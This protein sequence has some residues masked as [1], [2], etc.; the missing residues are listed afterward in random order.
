M[1]PPVCPPVSQSSPSAAA[2]PRSQLMCA[3]P[4]CRFRVH[5]KKELGGYCCI[6]CMEGGDHGPRCEQALAPHGARRADPNWL[7]MQGDQL[8]EVELD[9][10]LRLSML[11]ATGMSQMP[12]KP[13]VASRL[14]GK[15]LEESEL[16]EA[17]RLS[18]M[19][20]AV[21]DDDEAEAIRLSMLD[22]SARE[23]EAIR[24]STR[25]AA[26][27]ADVDEDELPAADSQDEDSDDDALPPLVPLDT[28][29]EQPDGEAQ[30]RD[31]HEVDEEQ[32]V[33]AAVE[34]AE[35]AANAADAARDQERRSSLKDL[36]RRQC[37]EAHKA[38]TRSCE[39][40]HT[41]VISCLPSGAFTCDC[42]NLG[43]NS[44]YSHRCTICDYDLCNS[45]YVLPLASLPNSK[46]QLGDV[47]EAVNP[48]ILRAEED[49][50]SAQIGTVPRGTLLYVV[51]IGVGPTGKRVFVSDDRNGYRGWISVVSAAGEEYLRPPGAKTPDRSSD[52]PR[53]VLVQQAKTAFGLSFMQLEEVTMLEAMGFEYGR[54][55]EAYLVCERNQENAANLLLQ[56][57]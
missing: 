41:L 49:M 15:E 13:P 47:Y 29:S 23:E 57:V 55:L 8:E 45:C 16:Q 52:A 48:L 35:V 40:G 24:S 53:E 39:K 42:C 18:M 20:D 14:S 54:A 4:G 51:Q 27:P 21:A 9:E 17:I 25:E 43:I 38:Q 19:D 37:E 30:I 36:D 10:A 22:A 32:R 31:T 28:G 6:V 7:A 34:A 56:Q 3:T 50:A 5:T 26:R 1:A 46:F 11:E 44:S 33:A 12:E 2:V